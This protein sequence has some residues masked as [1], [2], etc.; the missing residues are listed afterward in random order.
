MRLG[1]RDWG[2]DQGGIG[3]WNWG[4]IGVTIGAGIMVR[5]GQELG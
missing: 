5:L 1:R 3:G 4:K 2:R